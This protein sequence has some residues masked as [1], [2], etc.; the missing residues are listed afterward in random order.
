M[1][2][3]V[4]SIVEKGNDLRIE[5]LLCLVTCAIPSSGEAT[6]ADDLDV[7]END[8]LFAW[9]GSSGG[10]DRYHSPGSGPRI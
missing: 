4:V 3:I 1:G 7:E 8:W 2:V 10:L 5:A 6:P 9:G